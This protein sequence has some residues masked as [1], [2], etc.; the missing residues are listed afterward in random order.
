MSAMVRWT[1]EYEGDAFAR[2]YSSLP[3]YEQAVLTAA[4]EHV[5]SVLGI[6]ICESEWGKPLGGGLYEFRIRRSLRAIL[7]AASI[8]A[9]AAAS[10]RP[11]L[12]RVFCGFHGE[13]VVLL[14]GGYDKQRDP[15]T[16]RQQ[17]EIRRARQVH[18]AWRER[19]VGE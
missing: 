6:D 9:T 1:V 7:T 13:R 16:R 17:R 14:Y 3:E 5:L 4:I 19:R 11:V 8:D 15:S 2:F 10:G 18:M 12:L